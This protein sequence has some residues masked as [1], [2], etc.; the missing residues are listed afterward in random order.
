MSAPDL[1][2]EH[3]VRV[4]EAIGEA[5]DWTVDVQKMVMGIRACGYRIVPADWWDSCPTCDSI[6]KG[7]RNCLFCDVPHPTTP[8][9]PV[10]CTDNW[11]NEQ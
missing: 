6:S 1:P 5:S 11:H 3:D 4:M 2:E 7:Q 8:T 9:E 10:A